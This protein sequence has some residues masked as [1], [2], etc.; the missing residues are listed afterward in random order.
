MRAM[1]P[2]HITWKFSR[3]PDY[4]HGYFSQNFSWAFAPKFVALPVL[5]IICVTK[6]FR[7]VPGYSHAH[8]LSLPHKKKSYRP[9]D[10]FF[11]CTGFPAIFDWSFGWGLRTSN[12]GE[13]GRYRRSEMVP[14]ERV[15][16]GDFYINP[17]YTFIHQH[18]FARNF[19]L[20]FLV[21]LRT[22]NLGEEKAVWGR[23][24]YRSKE[25]WWVPIGPP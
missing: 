18:S 17:P 24:W 16:F 6:Q 7:T 4:A 21:G 20:E 5:E 3:L 15:Y 2:R 11:M 25:R 22:P 14:P 19:R 13:G 8:F 10:Y 1:R 23:R 12:L 9:S